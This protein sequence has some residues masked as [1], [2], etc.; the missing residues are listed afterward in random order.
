MVGKVEIVVASA[1]GAVVVMEALVV[2]KALVKSL[3]VVE[4]PLVVVVV[5]SRM[6]CLNS[7]MEMFSALFATAA[8]GVVAVGDAAVVVVGVVTIAVYAKGVPPP[9][10]RRRVDFFAL[11][12]SSWMFC[13][14]LYN[15]SSN[16]LILCF[17]DLLAAFDFFLVP[18]R[19]LEFP[20]FPNSRGLC[21]FPP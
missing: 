3:V 20:S 21:F 11:Q 15:C 7:S 18:V 4:S 10:M 1:V 17:M 9:L 2:V 14:A 12:R 5:V 16:N 19:F 8:V 13:C 6:A